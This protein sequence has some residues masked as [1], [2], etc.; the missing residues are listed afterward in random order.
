MIA[1]IEAELQK[2]DTE[3]GSKLNL[4]KPNVQGQISIQDLEETLR[5]IRDHPNDDRIKKIVTK[6]DSDKDGFVALNE[7]LTFKDENTEKKL[8]E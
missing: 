4:V 6:L 2:Y 1:S 7:L 8:N 5:A 3:I